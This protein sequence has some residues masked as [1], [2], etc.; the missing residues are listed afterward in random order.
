M[1]AWRAITGPPGRPG[2]PLTDDHP[3]VRALGRSAAE[4]TALLGLDAK[5]GPGWAFWRA[6][7]PARVPH[8]RLTLAL[9]RHARD[10]GL[11]MV[12]SHDR[13]GS[14]LRKL[15]TQPAAVDPTLPELPED[16]E[17]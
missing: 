7:P 5:P 13:L 3:S 15:S 16:D 14:S 1:D 9:A 12:L 17:G 10:N 2:E 8:L 11:G 6:A 4:V